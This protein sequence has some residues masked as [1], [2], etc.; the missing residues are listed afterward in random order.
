M[1]CK[2]QLICKGQASIIKVMIINSN[3]IKVRKYIFLRISDLSI[4]IYVMSVPKC[5]TLWSSF[6][7]TYS[8]MVLCLKY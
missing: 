7:I 8:A 6:V 5:I 1:T 4:Y 3:T 2:I